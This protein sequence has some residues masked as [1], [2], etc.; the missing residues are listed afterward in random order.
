MWQKILSEIHWLKPMDRDAPV[1]NSPDR[2]L[3]RLMGA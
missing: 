3:H 2:T 1:R